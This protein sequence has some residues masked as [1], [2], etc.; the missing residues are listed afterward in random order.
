MPILNQRLRSFPTESR[1]EIF[2]QCK[3]D[4]SLPPPINEGAVQGLKEEKIECKVGRK[5]AFPIQFS[6]NHSFLFF[7]YLSWPSA[8]NTHHRSSHH[9]LH[10]K[11]PSNHLTWWLHRFSLSLPYKF[12][13]SFFLLWPMPTSTIAIASED[14]V[15]ST[16]TT[17]DPYHL[18]WF[19]IPA[20]HQPSLCSLLRSFHA[21][22]SFP[23]WAGPVGWAKSGPT[24]IF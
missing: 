5:P 1:A 24:P 18:R 11:K 7:L 21:E 9:H 22:F 16:S 20:L 13:F 14:T 3:K 4:F 15:L 2:P 8:T 12:S 17:T 10:H 23:L 6:G 19:S